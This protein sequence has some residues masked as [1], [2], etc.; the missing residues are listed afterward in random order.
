[1]A[2]G[3]HNSWEKKKKANFILTMK[4][5]MAMIIILFGLK[6]IR[7]AMFFVHLLC[8]CR[9]C[10]LCKRFLYTFITMQ[11][12]INEW[13]TKKKKDSLNERID[14]EMPFSSSSRGCLLLCIKSRYC[15]VRRLATN[16]FVIGW[17]FCFVIKAAIII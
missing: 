5:M 4:I 13:I 9:S 17:L 12:R 6:P 1:M 14:T 11:T 2:K 15:D 10:M 3:K 16:A 7:F 8:Y